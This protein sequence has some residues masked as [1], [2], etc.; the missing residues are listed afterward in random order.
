[1]PERETQLYEPVKQLLVSLG[2]RVRAEVQSCDVVG[3]RGQELVVVELKRNLSFD[4]LAQAVERQSRADMVYLA[5]PEPARGFSSSKWKRVKR[6]LCRLD[7]GLILVSFK[8]H[9]PFA[10]LVL[11]PM[12]S[13]GRR[14]NK[15]KTSII[16]EVSARTRNENQG[17]TTRTKLMTAYRENALQI[18]CY[19]KVLGPMTPAQLRS[20]GTGPKTHSILY[21]NFYGWFHR[22]SRGIYDITPKA[23]REMAGFPGLVRHYEEV[24]RSLTRGG[25]GESG[26]RQMPRNPPVD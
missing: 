7:I 8:T 22:P 4:L 20:L 12:P 25:A 9:P 10:R 21:K 5:V 3:L 13:T 11:H 18:A 16:N 23:E 2:Y 24:L 15:R 19:I 17:G 1:M 6:L 26:D 14:S